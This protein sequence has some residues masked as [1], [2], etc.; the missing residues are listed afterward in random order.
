[1]HVR[2]RG[3][4]LE[5]DKSHP[6]LRPLFRRRKHSALVEKLVIAFERSN[7]EGSAAQRREIF[8]ELLA[9]IFSD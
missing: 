1:M 5:I 4:E 7:V 3:R 8:Y 2:S 6:L 9:Q